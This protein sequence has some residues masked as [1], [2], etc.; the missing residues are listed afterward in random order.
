MFWPTEIW[1]VIDV[2]QQ[3]WVEEDEM[4]AAG[5]ADRADGNDRNQHADGPKAHIAVLAIER[6]EKCADKDQDNDTQGPVNELAA[7]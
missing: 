5:R 2:I 7:G 4:P 1:R 3:E 6:D